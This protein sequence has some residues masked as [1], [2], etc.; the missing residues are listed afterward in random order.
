VSLA[1]SIPMSAAERTPWLT[2][3]EAAGRARCGVKLIYREVRACRLRAVRLGGRR[4]LRL[5][6]E[7]VDDWLLRHSTVEQRAL[8]SALR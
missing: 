8:T 6:A 1:E 3:E 5:L 2:V 4:E 7:W